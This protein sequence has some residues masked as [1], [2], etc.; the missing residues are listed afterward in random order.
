MEQLSKSKV[1]RVN[2]HGYQYNGGKRD[3][4]YKIV[5]GDKKALWNSEYGE[6]DSNGMPLAENLSLDL[7]WLHSTA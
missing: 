5:Q 1:G 7:Y 3:H 6:G 2:V 4:L